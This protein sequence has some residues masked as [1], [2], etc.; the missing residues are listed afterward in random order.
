MQIPE[1][2]VFEVLGRAHVEL[3]VAR[4]QLSHTQEQ[5]AA[6]LGRVAELEKQ[7]EV[8]CGPDC[9]RCEPMEGADGPAEG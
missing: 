1:N 8:A 6:A 4:A 2:F 5:L 9:D 3:A 7:P